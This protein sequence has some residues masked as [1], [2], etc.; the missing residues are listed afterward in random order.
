M[1]SIIGCEFRLSESEILNWLGCFGEVLSEITVEA[2]NAVYFDTPI[3]GDHLLVIA[4]LMFGSGPSGNNCLKRDWRSYTSTNLINYLAP[5]IRAINFDP[6]C[7]VQSL[8]NVLENLLITSVDAVAPLESFNLSC[9]VNK[10]VNKVPPTIKNKLN[11]RRRLIMLDRKRDN[12][13]HLDTIKL[14][15]CEIETY[16]ETSKKSRVQCVVMGKGN[17]GNIWKA[18]RVAKNLNA[19]SLS[20]NFTL[21]EEPI[22]T[23]ETAN[24]FGRF[25]S[26]KVSTLLAKTRLSPNVYNGKNKLIVLDRNFMSKN[27]VKECMY[28]IKS[29]R[30]EGYDRIPVNVICD[31]R[32]LLLDP[33]AV[34]FSKIYS[35]GLLPEQWKISKVIPI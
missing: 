11:K 23:C 33:Y 8:W 25:F 32:D 28:S 21:G 24:A 35:T 20:Q 17:S 2:L 22:A 9:N 26:L 3:F 16:F 4:E 27:D 5:L 6:N 12:N 30:C 13:V 1:V 34:L 19:D 15:S 31:A 14:L 10:S 29:K 7:N 18:V